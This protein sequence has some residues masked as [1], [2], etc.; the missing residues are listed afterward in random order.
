MTFNEFSCDDPHEPSLF[1]GPG[2][3]YTLFYEPGLWRIMYDRLPIPKPIIEIQDLIQPVYC[4]LCRREVVSMDEK[5][6]MRLFVSEGCPYRHKFHLDC[7][8]KAI[9]RIPVPSP[10][11]Q[12][13]SN[14]NSNVL[15]ALIKGREQ[16]SG[17]QAICFVCGSRMTLRDIQTVLGKA[18]RDANNAHW[19]KDYQSPFWFSPS[20]ERKE[21]SRNV[22]DR[23]KQ[24]FADA[25]SFAMRTTLFER[26]RGSAGASGGL[27]MR[28]CER[29]PGVN[30]SYDRAAVT[31]L[32]E[33][34]THL[35]YSKSCAE[36]GAILLD[37][38]DQTRLSCGHNLCIECGY[39]WL[40]F[41]DTNSIF[42]KA[43]IGLTAGAITFPVAFC[44][45][46]MKVVDLTG[47]PLHN[48]H[49]ISFPHLLRKYFLR[50]EP[51]QQCIH[52]NCQVHTTGL[53]GPRY[54]FLFEALR[55]RAATV[56]STDPSKVTVKCDG[57]LRVKEL[58]K[59]VGV[60]PLREMWL[61]N[62]YAVIETT[63][64][65]QYLI[66]YKNLF[67]EAFNE[68]TDP[69][70]ADIQR[71]LEGFD[72][73]AEEFCY[74]KPLNKQQ[75]ADSLKYVK[76]SKDPTLGNGIP[77]VSSI[78]S[79]DFPGHTKHCYIDALIHGKMYGYTLEQDS[80]YYMSLAGLPTEELGSL[81]ANLD[82]LLSTVGP[83]G[84]G[85]Y[86]S[87]NPNDIH[88]IT[89]AR[90]SRYYMA[91]VLL[92]QPRAPAPA[93]A[94]APSRSAGQTRDPAQG[95]KP[96]DVNPIDYT[97]VSADQIP[98]GRPDPSYSKQEVYV[99][100]KQ[101]SILRVTIHQKHSWVVVFEP[102]LV[103]PLLVV[104]YR[105]DFTKPLPA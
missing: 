16:R 72:K 55:E 95:H 45:H 57:L 35:A 86:L 13:S 6:S 73:T 49:Y 77:Q 96:H 9:Y 36:C 60:T 78:E 100:Q 53:F 31:K 67:E 93:P 1:Y 81:G 102:S 8:M 80:Y 87:K 58:P 44:S 91:I 14:P 71:L 90:D 97:R 56:D 33:T 82:A 23:E 42:F 20:C 104:S 79:I 62:R 76:D 3:S 12:A 22:K 88:E 68:V 51:I 61:A 103:V 69:K 32:L 24:S 66:G 11:G 84:R 27:G 47:L 48:D 98:A 25:K 65:K 85:L 38:W 75:L 26:A 29:C 46:C 52:Q 28:I 18:Y 59:Y 21:T 34:T 43:S 2:R 37:R 101:G 4:G 63:K 92:A 89:A 40:Q 15:E 70:I 7:I 83:F 41:T 99:G 105:I 17:L 64:D 54:S 19:K 30:H 5:D 10:S 39:N 94:P 74:K 50:R